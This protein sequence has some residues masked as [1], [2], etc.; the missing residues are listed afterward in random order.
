MASR[1]HNTNLILWSFRDC[2]S[3]YTLT[4]VS[5]SYPNNDPVDLDN[6]EFSGNCSLETNEKLNIRIIF[7]TIIA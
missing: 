3:V 7:I 2:V 4:N 6:L 5:L 1:L